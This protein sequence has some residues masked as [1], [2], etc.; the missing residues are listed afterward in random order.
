MK[1]EDIIFYYLKNKEDKLSF[2]KTAKDFNENLLSI[3][4]HRSVNIR[5]RLKFSYASSS[6]ASFQSFLEVGLE[7]EKPLHE[8]QGINK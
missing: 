2:V 3:S 7:V 5:F 6:W 8:R 1:S 4:K